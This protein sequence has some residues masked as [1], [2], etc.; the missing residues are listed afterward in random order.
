MINTPKLVYA[1]YS[2]FYNNQSISSSMLIYTKLLN[3]NWIY[4]C[5]NLFP[6]LFLS[7]QI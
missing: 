3:S 4:F 5:D 2:F 7:I 1:G 6:Y